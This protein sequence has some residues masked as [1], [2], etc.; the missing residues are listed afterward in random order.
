M[1]ISRSL[2][3]QQMTTGR[4][5]PY[6]SRFRVF[7]PFAVIFA[8]AIL[9]LETQKDIVPP[10]G[11]PLMELIDQEARG[12]SGERPFTLPALTGEIVQL[13]DFRGNVVVLNFFA[14][15]CPPCREEMP[16]LEAL[17]QANKNRGLAVVGIAADPDGDKAIAPFAKEY[18]LTFPLLL[19]TKSEVFRLYFVNNIPVT[20][21]IDKQGRIAGMSRGGADWN[22]PQAQELVDELLLES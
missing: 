5:K 10:L 2:K 7:F 17:Y 15:W 19:D 9:A 6:S 18:A 12:G 3:F 20:Y 4:L 13:S 21:L 11:P 22:S 8:V 1:N 16:S 14:T